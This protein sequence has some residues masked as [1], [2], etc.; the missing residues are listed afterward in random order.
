MADLTSDAMVKRILRAAKIRVVSNP[1]FSAGEAAGQTELSITPTVD[2]RPGQILTLG[3]NDS[4][5]T[6]DAEVSSKTSTTVTVSGGITYAYSL[7]DPVTPDT[8]DIF[9]ADLTN[10]RTERE[11]WLRGRLSAMYALTGDELT[12]SATWVVNLLSFIASRLTAWDVYCFAHPDQR[13]DAKPEVVQKWR[14]D[15]VELLDRIVPEDGKVPEIILEG[16]TPIGPHVA[17]A[18]ARAR[19]QAGQRLFPRYIPP[20]EETIPLTDGDMDDEED[21]RDGVLA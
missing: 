8:E 20:E 13:D 14:E 7:G 5:Q 15:A 2:I 11:S 16:E 12:L 21:V 10:F 6:E 9:S 3:P 18:A 4:G 19:I 1:T 17:K